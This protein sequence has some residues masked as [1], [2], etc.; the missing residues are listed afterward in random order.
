M[1]VAERAGGRGPTVRV[2]GVAA[3]AAAAFAALAAARLEPRER[4]TGLAGE[5]VTDAR[6]QR[7]RAHAGGSE[8]L[9]GGCRW[10]GPGQGVFHGCVRASRGAWCACE[11][12][13]YVF[14]DRGD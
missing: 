13:L 5:G 6:R 2:P 12:P 7:R 4:L 10:A 8:R 14:W 11:D 3:A 1:R 9:R